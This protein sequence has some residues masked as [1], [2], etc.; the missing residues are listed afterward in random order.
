MVK[1]KNL[2]FIHET[3]DA[4]LEQERCLFEIF[5]G[6]L[7]EAPEPT[8]IYRAYYGYHEVSLVTAM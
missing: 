8:Y 6:P 4:D 3:L 1:E 2:S 7:V 5:S